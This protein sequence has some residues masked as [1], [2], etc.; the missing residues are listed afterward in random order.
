MQTRQL[1]H[2]D[3]H[4]TPLGLGAWAI[5][6][7]GYSFG[8]GPQDE[9]ASIATI[10]RALDL[11]INW[12]DTAAVYGL[13]RSEEIIGRAL[14]VRAEKPYVFTTCGLE[15]TDS[16]EI[17]H[18]LSRDSIG[19]GVQASLSRLR[20]KT[21][22]LCQVHSPTPDSDIEE[23][24]WTLVDLQRE[25]SIRAIG[26]SNFAVGQ[27]KRAM[28]IT[29]IASLQSQYSLVHPEAELH[30]LPFCAAGG[31]G[32]IVYSPMGCG[33][34][35][36]AMTTQRVAHLPDDD[37]R[38]RSDEFH[39]ERL[40][41]HRKLADLLGAI[42]KRHGGAS[43]GAVAVAWTLRATAVTGAIVGAR[44]PSQI[45][46]IVATA[47]LRLTQEDLD[48]IATFVFTNPEPGVRRSA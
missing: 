28:A 32:V 31:V 43:A 18:N 19:R 13:G 9:G 8:W 27:L 16:G 37:W 40:A 14:A 7:G 17:R 20:R 11:G 12:I 48:E 39:G 47:D 10:H 30:E 33:L 3:L 34:L 42:G 45:E 6:G 25:G 38:K 23:A 29:T 24:L 4:I 41:R 46:N 26:V 15:W 21:I 44:R 36:G 1:G 35:T 22:D 2:S 5:G